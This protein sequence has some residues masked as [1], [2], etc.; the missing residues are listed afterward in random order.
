MIQ[1]PPNRTADQ[2]ADQN[3]ILPPESPEPGRWRTSRIPFFR[4]IMRAFSA[5][6]VELIVIVCGA[7]MGK[8]EAMMCVLGHRFDDGPRVPTLWIA[9]TQ[10]SVKSL[11]DDRVMK[12]LRATPALWRILEKGRRNRVVEKY[13]A[14]VRLGFGWAGSAT[15][16]ASHP[17]GLVLV[18]ERDRMISDVE[19]EGDPLVLA[20]A[21]TKNYP[22]RKIGVSSTPTIEG[23]SPIW[24]LFLEGTAQKWAW[25]CW[26]CTELFVP[27][28]KLLRWPD[29]ATPAEARAKASVVCPHCG[30]ELHDHHKPKMNAE[31]RYLASV[32]DANGDEQLEDAPA[33]NATASFWISGLA[34]PW[35]TFGEIAQLLVAAYRSREPE[36]IQGVV[37]TYGGE[38]WR[39]SGEAPEWES[40]FNTRGGYGR[41]QVPPGVRFLVMGVDVQKEG[42]WWAI[43]GFGVNAE[44]WGI[45]HGYLF[46]E[47]E[48]D[49]VWITLGSHVQKLVGDRRLDRVFIDSGYKPGSLYRRPQNVIYSFCRR[50]RGLVY[51]TKGWRQQDKPL[52]ANDIDLT[53]G[54]RTLRAAVKLWHLDTNYLKTWIYAQIQRPEGEPN[55]WHSHA[56]IDE[57]YCKQLVS[58]ERLVKASGE[59]AWLEKGPNHLL[60]CETLCFAAALSL[61]VWALRADDPLPEPPEKSSQKGKPSGRFQRREL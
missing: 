41:G 39:V 34:S 45:D 19:G 53:V 27:S 5:G 28:L 55:T 49:N 3:R 10:K 42:L 35:Q 15:E 47:T 29:K 31:G 2:W 12:M 24:S 61:N 33:P 6:D 7:Q 40:V 57:E 25:P 54:G 32:I 20:R 22:L 23:S 26:H 21:R 1:P 11:A 58:E 14:G 13:L 59:V 50:F 30:A 52:K 9:P 38:V 44:S 36:R 43:R 4:P 8:T 18:D 48:Y 60:D 51:P 46:G 16:L 56:Q 37:N 17:A